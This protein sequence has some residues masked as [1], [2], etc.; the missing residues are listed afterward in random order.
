M[1]NIF[2]RRLKI[3]LFGESHSAAIGVTIDGLPAGF[4]P[5]MEQVAE[6]MQRRAP[7]RDALSTPRKESDEVKI[8]CGLHEGKTTG[9]PLTAIIENHN[10][11]SVHYNKEIPRPG[12]AD[13]AAHVKFGGNQDARGGGHFSGRI[14]APLVFAGALAKQCLMARG[15]V[16]GAR[17]TKIG[18][19]ED[20]KVKEIS[21]EQLIQL[22]AQRIPTLSPERA[23]EMEA[24][25]LCAKESGD[26]V[27]GIVECHILGVDAPIGSPFFHS[28]ESELA[29]LMFSVP[30]VKGLEFGAGFAFAEM[31]GSQANDALQYENGKVETLTNHNGGL[32][33]GIANGMPIVFRVAV[34]PTPSVFVPQ[35]TVN[36]NTKE[37]I[38]HQIQGRHDPCIVPR[39]V[40]VIEA[41]AALAVLDG[42]LYDG[43][44]LL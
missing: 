43:Y 42:Y 18:A 24:Q 1:G 23:R 30:A 5:D 3:S 12:H 40:P 4:T 14:T 22:R 37:N 41:A 7:G 32:N 17:I 11:V 34:K 20:I 35:Q 13:Y 39:V 16:I 33:G 25:I 31:Q 44:A 19:A 21:P 15:I 8:L 36:L 29:V 10:T 2:G 28:L 6:E 38:T 27:G 26:S 9:A